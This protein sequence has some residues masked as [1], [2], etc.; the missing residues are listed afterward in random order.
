MVNHSLMNMGKIPINRPE[1]TN[2][3]SSR[4]KGDGN[5]VYVERRDKFGVFDI[6]CLMFVKGK[7]LRFA[8]RNIN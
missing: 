1:D 5:L 7:K 3:F 8:G 2:M 4:D 6:F